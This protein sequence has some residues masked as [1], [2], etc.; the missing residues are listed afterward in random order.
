[1][2]RRYPNPIDVF[3]MALD[4][5]GAHPTCIH[6]DD[7]VIKTSETRLSFGYD[8]RLERSLPVPGRL[9]FQLPKVPLQL[10]P[11]T[12]V[13]AVPAVVPRYIVLLVAQMF[14]QLHVQRPFQDCLGYLL[15]QAVFANYVF[16]LLVVGQQLF[17]AFLI[18]CHRSL[19]SSPDSRLHSPFYTL[20]AIGIWAITLFTSALPF[21]QPSRRI[22][23]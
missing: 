5:A 12:A 19:F 10:L 13:A 14:R 23:Q 15:Q 21:L 17:N 6:G 4:L 8:L 3:Q 20:M 9:Q 22:L 16:R 2:R 7:F 11:T 18:D 1:Q